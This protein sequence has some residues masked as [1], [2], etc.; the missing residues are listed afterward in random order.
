LFLYAQCIKRSGCRDKGWSFRKRTSN[1][2]ESRTSQDAIAIRH[3]GTMVRGTCVFILGITNTEPNLS[4][5][6]GGTGVFMPLVSRESRNKRAVR[7]SRSALAKINAAKA[8]GTQEG[9]DTP[10]AGMCPWETAEA[11]EAGSAN[12][13]S[14]SHPAPP[15]GRRPASFDMSGI[16]SSTSAL[17][18]AA[19]ATTTTP[20]PSF[21]SSYHGVYT[22]PMVQA[23]NGCYT[24]WVWVH[25]PLNG[26]S[27]LRGPI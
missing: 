25:D 9:V 21:D 19:P 23:G 16:S 11:V 22:G 24:G 7:R 6:L 2:S 1:D 15:A 12:A 20:R 5:A 3:F 27:T 4:P 14:C 17:D 10:V 13:S 8:P 18:A 26:R